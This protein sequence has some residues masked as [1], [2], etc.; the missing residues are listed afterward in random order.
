MRCGKFVD[1]PALQDRRR[2]IPDPV[3]VEARERLGKHRTLQACAAPVAPAIERDIHS[4]DGPA[5]RPRKPGH[6]VVTLL[7]QRLP[8]RGRGN[9]AYEITRSN[10][11][12]EVFAPLRAALFEEDGKRTTILMTRPNFIKSSLSGEGIST[13]AAAVLDQFE[14]DMH[15]VLEN[16]A[17]GGF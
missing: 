7:Q 13:E 17:F 11:A 10:P 8:A 16:V 1:R 4:L 6:V 15:E 14:S 12:F 2:A 3:D 9:Q 5:P